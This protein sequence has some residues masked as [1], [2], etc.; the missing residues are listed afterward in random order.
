MEHFYNIYGVRFRIR[1]NNRLISFR[2]GRVLEFFKIRKIKKIAVNLDFMYLKD[3]AFKFRLPKDAQLLDFFDLNFNGQ[4]VRGFTYRKN[5]KTFLIQSKLM[6]SHWNEWGGGCFIFSNLYINSR[7]MHYLIN[8]LIL[9]I[10][11]RR[12]YFP[13]HAAGVA[14]DKKGIL[15]IGDSG[16]GK[17]TIAAYLTKRGFGFLGDDTVLLRRRSNLWI[18]PFSTYLSLDKEKP[19]KYFL[20]NKNLSRLKKN[21]GWFKEN[22]KFF[23]NIKKLKPHLFIERAPLTLLLFPILSNRAESSIE[24]ISF[25]E[26]FGIL[27]KNIYIFEVKEKGLLLGSLL[28][29]RPYFKLYLG[30]N[31]KGLET[32]IKDII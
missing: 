26:A 18:Y 25:A 6:Y 11:A 22:G 14:V 32:K 20:K 1:T 7:W 15:F 9:D 8:T 24:R 17:S 28:K 13:I 21:N 30:K 4:D 2:L 27:S 31:L 23:L 16:K 19:F 10:L 12:G 29:K 3:K 5:N